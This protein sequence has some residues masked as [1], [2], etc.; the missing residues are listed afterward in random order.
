ME[1]LQSTWISIIVAQAVVIIY[2]TVL[3]R[4]SLKAPP[5]AHV[6]RRDHIT[7]IYDTTFGT[8]SYSHRIIRSHCTK[9]GT[10]KNFKAK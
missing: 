6:W 5:C 7:D 8:R 1:V 10:W 3:Y 2:L 9:C 4:N